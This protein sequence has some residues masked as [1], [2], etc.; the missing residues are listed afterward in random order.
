MCL[1]GT[2]VNMAACLRFGTAPYLHPNKQATGQSAHALTHA[3]HNALHIEVSGLLYTVIQHMTK[4]TGKVHL[5]SQHTTHPSQPPP[6]H[7]QIGAASKSLSYPPEKNPGEISG[8]PEKVARA[9]HQC[10]C[11]TVDCS[12][13]MLACLS[14]TPPHNAWAM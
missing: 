9:I 4:H 12:V 5:S 8:V 2:A 11:H 10:K 13:G 14:L 7:S 1:D 3:S 6:P